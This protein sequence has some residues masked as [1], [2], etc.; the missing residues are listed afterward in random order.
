MEDREVKFWIEHPNWIPP[1][2]KECG[3]D[4]EAIK[5]EYLAREE[6]ERR[7]G[8][9]KVRE[10]YEE[11]VENMSQAD[12]TAFMNGNPPKNLMAIVEPDPKSSHLM[13]RQFP[14]VIIGN[15][16]DI[17]RKYTPAEEDSEE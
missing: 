17:W 12:V 2:T 9:D 13:A 16:M 7:L 6:E 8:I 10:Q 11:I 3:M 14:G 15:V 1:Y 5:T 4:W